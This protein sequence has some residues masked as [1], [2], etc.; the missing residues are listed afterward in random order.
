LRLTYIED[1]T[2]DEVVKELTVSRR[3]YFYDLK[4]AVGALAYHLVRTR[5]VAQLSSVA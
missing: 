4:D 2:V 5:Q 3:Q 1:R